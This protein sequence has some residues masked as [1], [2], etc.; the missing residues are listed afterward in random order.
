MYAI[1]VRTIQ[2]P[3]K[4]EYRRHPERA[5][6]EDVVHSLPSDLGD[7][8]RVRVG[9]SG[10]QGFEIAIGVH[11]GVG[12]DGTLPCSG[13]VLA[14]ALA[15]CQELSV[16]MV[17]ANM[18]VE[19]EDVRVEVTAQGDLRGA[20]GLDRNTKVG[21]ERLQIRTHVKVRGGDPD[22]AR[23]LLEAAERYCAILDTLRHPPAIDA[24]FTLDHTPA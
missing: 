23:R 19:L 5:R 9:R 13:D 6:I 24:S 14:A 17:A 21:L 3:I 4:D 11:R 22:R 10:P 15:G 1:D 16:R 18:G 2:T 7:P 12:G 20:L 8:T